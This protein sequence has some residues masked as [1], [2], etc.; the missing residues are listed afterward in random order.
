[1]TKINSVRRAF[2]LWCAFLA[3]GVLVV[4]GAASAHLSDN[5]IP[6]PFFGQR[7]VW[8]KPVFSPD[9][10]REF[11]G[12]SPGVGAPGSCLTCISDGISTGGLCFNVGDGVACGHTQERC[13]TVGQRVGV[14]GKVKVTCADGVEQE[15][16]WSIEHSFAEQKCETITAGE[17]QL[18]Y[19]T[20]CY[21]TS[22]IRTWLCHFVGPSGE[23]RRHRHD[24]RIGG[25][26]IWTTRCW[27]LPSNQP[28][29]DA[30]AD[31]WACE[32]CA[33]SGHDCDCVDSSQ[34]TEPPMQTVP[35][36]G[37]GNPVAVH[38]T[39]EVGISGGG[40]DTLG[41][42]GLSLVDL[43]G[44]YSQLVSAYLEH[45][46]AGETGRYYLG[47]EGAILASGSAMDIASRINH[48]AMTLI[49]SPVRGDLDGDG[50][51][52]AVD[53]TLFIETLGGAYEGTQVRVAAD[54]DADL[55][56]DTGDFVI[57]VENLGN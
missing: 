8:I 29:S 25:S 53:V 20:A 43:A 52:T 47:R 9:P 21:G 17:C 34:P 50:R 22:S 13:I 30:A 27:G 54:L 44:A 46:E 28:E 39:I 56:L 18:C 31:A 45:Q 15:L 48:A 41:I 26:V 37:T 10:E 38:C 2:G 35:L 5:P 23:W 7:P 6:D 36:P 55:S 3:A 51:V 19:L 40:G 12:G 57:L 32:L 24:V 49:Q 1:M 14:S 11:G 16:G 42:A 33:N 4:S